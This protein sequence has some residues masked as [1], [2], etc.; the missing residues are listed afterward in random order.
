MTLINFTNITMAN[1]TLQQLQA[2]HL[3]IT[4]GWFAILLCI[5]LFIII[6]ISM[7]FYEVGGAFLIASFFTTM[8]AGLFWMAGFVPTI[9]FVS[10]TIFMAIGVVLVTFI[11]T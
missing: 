1:S 2:I 9:V 11:K 4:G 7:S 3:D 6:F 8:I 5:S 10:A